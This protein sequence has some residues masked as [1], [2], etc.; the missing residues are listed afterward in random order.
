LST[1]NRNRDDELTKR[2]LIGA[3]S[4]KIIRLQIKLSEISLA[5]LKLVRS[6]FRNKIQKRR[7]YK[8]LRIQPAVR[9]ASNLRN[10]LKRV[11]AQVFR[12][13]EKGKVVPFSAE[14]RATKK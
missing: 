3:L 4:K 9:R 12:H 7:R 8:S 14:E 13:S 2:R 11:T 5:R 1:E 6:W 10:R